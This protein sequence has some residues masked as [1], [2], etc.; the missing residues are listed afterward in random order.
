MNFFL[1]ISTNMEF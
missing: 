1:L